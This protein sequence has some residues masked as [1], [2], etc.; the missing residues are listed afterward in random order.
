MLT[1]FHYLIIAEQRPSFWLG[2]RDQ[3][4]ALAILCQ[5]MFHKNVVFD[6]AAK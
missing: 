6:E 4:L 3:F 2:H 1:I 5:Q